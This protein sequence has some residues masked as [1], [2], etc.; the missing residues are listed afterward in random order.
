MR[1]RVFLLFLFIGSV[2]IIDS[3]SKKGGTNPPPP[4]SVPGCATNS[5]PANGA[6]VTPG[7]LTLSWTSVIGATGYD[8]Y[9]GASPSTTTL[10]IASNVSGTSYNY[11][12]PTFASSQL[13]YWYVQPKNASGGTSGCS[14]TATSFMSTIIQDPFPFGY[15]VVGYFPS[16]RNL[17]EVPD[18]PASS[19]SRSSCT[20]RSWFTAHP[21]TINTSTSAFVHVHSDRFNT[22][23][24]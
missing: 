3:C 15:Y 17:A 24:P 11:S 6:F 22:H 12:V 20:S 18:F 1:F 10:L 21:L 2:I 9:V 5:A 16:Y 4:N 13:L 19:T 23:P 8:I 7:P 14:S